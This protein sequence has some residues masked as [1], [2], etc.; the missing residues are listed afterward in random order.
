MRQLRNSRR[1]SF[2]RALVA[3]SKSFGERDEQQIAHAAADQV[4]GVAV[5]RQALQHLDRVRVDAALRDLIGVDGRCWDGAHGD[6]VRAP[7]R[8]GRPVVGQL[9]L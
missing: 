4:R 7:R 5:A 3:M 9:W 1:T 8:L 6:R 2:G